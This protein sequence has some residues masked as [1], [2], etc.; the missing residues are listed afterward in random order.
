MIWSHFKSSASITLAP[1]A[2][3]AS[4]L[5][6]DSA[7]STLKIQ[8]YTNPVSPPINSHHLHVL[9]PSLPHSLRPTPSSSPRPILNSK[10][11]ILLHRILGIDP[12]LSIF[13][14]TT[15]IVQLLELLSVPNDT[16]LGWFWAPL[17]F[18]RFPWMERHDWNDEDLIWLG[19]CVCAWALCI[20]SIG[21]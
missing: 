1:S 11:H 15:V 4:Y 17:R 21:M 9:H 6:T 12:I 2:P 3:S 10:R 20:W 18:D 7:T 8:L 13:N 5:I 19:N 14:S 16:R